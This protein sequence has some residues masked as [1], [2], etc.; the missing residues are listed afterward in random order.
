MSPKADNNTGGGRLSVYVPGQKGGPGFCKLFVSPKFNAE[1]D[2]VAVKSFMNADRMEAKWS[3]V[4][5]KSV[6]ILAQAEVDKTGASYYGKTQVK[7]TTCNILFDREKLPLSFALFLK[8]MNIRTS[9]HPFTMTRYVRLFF[10]T[11]RQKN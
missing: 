6:L 7:N 4:D 3:G 11:G 10:N 8:N 1:S 5:G 9:N 2:A